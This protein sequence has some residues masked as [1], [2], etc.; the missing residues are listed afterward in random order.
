MTNPIARTGQSLE[1]HLRGTAQRAAVLASPFQCEGE[2]YTAGLWHDLGK[3][4][5]EEQ[6]DLVCRR[7]RQRKSFHSAVGALHVLESVS[8][9]GGRALALAIASHHTGLLNACD[10][11]KICRDARRDHASVVSALSSSI[12]DYSPVPRY[13]KSRFHEE[14]FGRLLFSCLVN[15]DWADA[16]AHSPGRA[17]AMVYE[18]VPSEDDSGVLWAATPRSGRR[19]CSV[20][21]GIVEKHD[22]RKLYDPLDTLVRVI[23]M[24]GFA[25]MVAEDRAMLR[26]RRIAERVAAMR[27][28]AAGH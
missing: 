22:P 7:K 8:G 20:A 28:G 17:L 5:R 15:A 24:D 11:G 2:A 18:E 27:E 6:R 26:Y 3:A 19:F 16:A 4:T 10:L 25:A 21:K 14:V 1:D 23:A 12:V 9:E 13:F